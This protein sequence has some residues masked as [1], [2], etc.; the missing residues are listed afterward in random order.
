MGFDPIDQFLDAAASTFGAG[1]V[2]EF[3]KAPVLFAQRALCAA[4]LARKAQRLGV[5]TIDDISKARELVCVLEIL[6]LEA[7][8]REGGE[9][10]DVILATSAQAVSAYREVVDS[11]R[12]V[13]GPAP[14]GCPTMPAEELDGILVQEGRSVV[15][16]LSMTP[17]NLQR[18]LGDMLLT[19]RRDAST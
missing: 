17:R 15:L 13:V 6:A 19:Q 18:A 2:E 14:V 12:C 16:Y 5:L 3:V 9:T 4:S 8:E 1:R 11:L 10:G 7:V